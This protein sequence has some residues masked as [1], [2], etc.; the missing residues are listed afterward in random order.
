MFNATVL[1][2][3]LPV[4][5]GGE[6]G[7][8]VP[9]EIG[10]AG[11]DLA[12]KRTVEVYSRYKP[13]VKKENYITPAA[14]MTMHECPDGATGVKDIMI[15]PGI[16]PGMN[17]GL[18]VESQ[19]LSGVPVYYG[20]GDTF[21]DIQY[22]D[23]RRRWIKTVAR[24]LA[25]DPDWAYLIDPDSGKLKLYT[26]GSQQLFIDV[27]L[28]FP[29]KDDLTTIPFH[30]QKWVSEW[31]LSEA[32][33]IVGRSRRKYDKIPVAGTVMHLDGDAMIAEATGIQSRLLNEIQSSRADLFPRY[34]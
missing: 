17:S 26:Y 4:A 10:P 15:S 8:G 18:T 20:V 13:W 33:M 5:L 24:E 32:M 27:E 19:L 7:V 14:G 22:L 6:T 29:H 31:A 2:Q 23:L 30:S 3:E 11:L 28:T 1:K 16:S 9:I 12:I 25:S 34:V 21:M